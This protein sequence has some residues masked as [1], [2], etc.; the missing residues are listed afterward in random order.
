MCM[1]V[2]YTVVPFAPRATNIPIPCATKVVR[3][4]PVLP[5]VGLLWLAATA[6]AQTRTF[7]ASEMSVTTS[8]PIFLSFRASRLRSRIANANLLGGKSVG[9]HAADNAGGHI[10]AANKCD[11]S[12]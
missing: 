12:H 5:P 3:V 4:V 7:M 2:M 6:S 8:R 9:E 1:Y 11:I 10:A